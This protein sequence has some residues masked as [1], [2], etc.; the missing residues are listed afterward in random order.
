MSH[1]ASRRGADLPYKL[2]AG[3]EPFPRGWL[4][5]TARLHGVTMA[6][7]PPQF[8]ERLTDILDS[9]PAFQVIA[10]HI[11]IGLA[12]DR[13]HRPR[14]CDREARRLIG[15]PRAAAVVDPPV[16]VALTA[17]SYQMARYRNGGSL[18]P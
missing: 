2:L 10:I 11:P 5:V 8:F 6:P 13:W 15:F 17:R 1:P 9:K 14:A 16:R 18:N 4:V 7:Q 3:V 12:E